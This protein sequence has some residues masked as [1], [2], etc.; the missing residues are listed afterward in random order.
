MNFNSN[1]NETQPMEGIEASNQI[2]HE[3]VPSNPPASQVLEHT[4]LSSSL[5][6]LQE[7]ED[8]LKEEIKKLSVPSDILDRFKIKELKYHSKLTHIE[9][10]DNLVLAARKA[11]L[12]PQLIM[13]M[14]KILSTNQKEQ[15]TPYGENYEHLSVWYMNHSIKNHTVLRPLYI[16]ANGVIEKLFAST[17]FDLLKK[18]IKDLDGYSVLSE[19]STELLRDCCF[20]PGIQPYLLPITVKVFIGRTY[21]GSN[22]TTK[23]HNSIGQI[24]DFFIGKDLDI[25][26]GNA[27][28]IEND[29]V[30]IANFDEH[31]SVTQKILHRSIDKVAVISW[32][33]YFAKRLTGETKSKFLHYCIKE[34]NRSATDNDKFNSSVIR[35]FLDQANM[36]KNKRL[37]KIQTPVKITEMGDEENQ[38]P[39]SDNEVVNRKRSLEPSNNIKPEKK[40]QD[41]NK[42]NEPYVFLKRGLGIKFTKPSKARVPP[43]TKFCEDCG[44]F[45][46]QNNKTGKFLHSFVEGKY[47]GRF[48]NHA[49]ALDKLMRKEGAK[50]LT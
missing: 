40:R 7:A 45:E 13:M 46:R 23:L 27:N 15:L 34:L 35:E 31:I 39:K 26:Y 17:N 48:R 12:N 14:D 6:T 36:S 28:K 19:K 10:F 8:A 1:I 21:G 47:V 33:R 30:F 3:D 16:V 25:I 24:E 43:Y 18:E 42:N 38:K 9:Y 20:A 4:D 32:V 49:I 50:D 29:E 41:I 5:V 44:V 22:L 11:T 2:N 37:I